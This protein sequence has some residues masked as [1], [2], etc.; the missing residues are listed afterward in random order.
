MA[1]AKIRPDDASFLAAR[2]LEFFDAANKKG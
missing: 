2:H 1:I